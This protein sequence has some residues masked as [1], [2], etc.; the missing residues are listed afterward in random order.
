MIS[1]NAASQADTRPDNNQRRC[2][3]RFE[4]LYPLLCL[5]LVEV[6]SFGIHIGQI[7]V[8]QDEWISFGKLHFIMHS[9]P[10]LIS[11]FFWD[12]RVIVRPLEA[13]HFPPLYF[14]VWEQPFWYHAVCYLFELLGG[15]FLLL[16]VARLSGNRAVALAAAVLFLLYPNH[17]ATHYSIVASSTSVAVAFLTLSLWLFL[18]GIAS[19]NSGNCLILAA[20]MSYFLSVYTYELSL[21]LV[22]LYPL[23]S[24]VTL[25]SEK[26]S[27]ADLKRLAV[28]Q[29]PFVLV[30]GTM[31]AYR[32]WVL[33]S[34][35]LGWHY[36]MC[37]SLQ[38][39]LSVI[40]AGVQVT[41]SPY[42]LN[43][44]LSMA[45]DLVKETLPVASWIWLAVT[46]CFVCAC[47]LQV[48]TYSRSS[49]K[50]LQVIFVGVVT[51]LCSYTIYGL[52]PEHAPVLQGWL[53]RVNIGGSLGSSLVVAGLLGVIRDQ[54]RFAG[55]V[56]QSTAFAVVLS[57]LS[58]LFIM[59]NWQFAKPWIVSWQAQKQLVFFLR[60]HTSEINSGDSIIIGGITRYV[61]WAPVL[62][63]VWDFQN[64][65]RTT[66]NDDK[67]NGTVLTDR[68]TVEKDALFDR[69]GSLVL[70]VFPFKQMILYSPYKQQWFRVSTRQ[71]FIEG[72]RQLRW[73]IRQRPII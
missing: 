28:Y 37:F 50:S 26:R 16:A 73:T 13:L 21:P 57:V 7:G 27:P 43:F 23:L 46:V 39:F 47:A 40:V 17:D 69:S 70:G 35:N 52:S 61:R 58:G 38:H 60:H 41:F 11:A 2:H 25:H 63:G 64:I 5:V 51:L 15:W 48:G 53:N 54:L 49:N 36:G 6:A 1:K 55:K 68:L 22:V 18:K 12:P 29:S 8:Y 20:G 72:A 67:I 30:A 45:S 56:G 9:L 44:C 65:V 3:Q 62:D 33:P 14:F 31:I 66:L 71:G 34:L 59:V 32:L 19:R 42:F 10:A 4:F 24:L